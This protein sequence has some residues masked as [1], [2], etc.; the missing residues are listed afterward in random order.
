MSILKNHKTT[1]KDFEKIKKFSTIVEKK[2]SK[3]HHSEEEK[4]ENYSFEELQD[5]NKILQLADYMLCKYENRKEIHSL[6]KEFVSMINH[7]AQSVDVL[8]DDIDELVISAEGALGRIKDLQGNVSE[9]FIIGAK[10]DAS[11]EQIS[12]ENDG[13]N[14]LT[15]N[16]TALYTQEYQAKSKV[17]TEQVI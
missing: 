1:A 3:I 4:I 7:S 6:L 14:N 16:H 13:A 5:L 15:K 2:L 9:R 8:N 12:A 11:Q 10:S 17:E